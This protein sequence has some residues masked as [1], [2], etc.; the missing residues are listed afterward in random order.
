MPYS[1][2]IPQS[3]IKNEVN[4][5]EDKRPS[6]YIPVSD[7]ARADQYK[8][9][10]MSFLG[11]EISLIFPIFPTPPTHMPVHS[12]DFATAAHAAFWGR[13]ERKQKSPRN[14]LKYP[15]FPKIRT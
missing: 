14:E 2:K 7:V 13:R 9:D 12:T 8:E 4:A 5:L 10:E 3:C 6:L 15:W 1:S 11:M